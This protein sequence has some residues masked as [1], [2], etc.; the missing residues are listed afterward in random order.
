MFQESQNIRFTVD[1][2]PI[3]NTWKNYFTRQFHSVQKAVCVWADFH[4]IKPSWPTTVKVSMK[5][6]FTLSIF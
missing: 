5:Q 2:H 6:K 3:Q 4:N 1:S